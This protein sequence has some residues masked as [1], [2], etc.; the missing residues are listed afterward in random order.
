MLINPNLYL[1][2]PLP[3]LYNP[4]QLHFLSTT[5]LSQRSKCLFRVSSPRFTVSDPEFSQSD[6]MKTLDVFFEQWTLPSGFAVSL[7]F[8]NDFSFF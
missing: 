1:L 2:T 5:L 8:K 6:E 4:T 7:I 3:S